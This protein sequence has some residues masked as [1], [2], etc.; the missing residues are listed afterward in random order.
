MKI[1]L[2]FETSK[3]HILPSVLK[4][5]PTEDFLF[6]E[7]TY[8]NWSELCSPLIVEPPRSQGFSLRDWGW[9]GKDTGIG[10][11]RGKTGVYKLCILIYELLWF[12]LSV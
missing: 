10:L 11:S 4:Y 1:H 6:I 12:I 5:I 9:A 3:S 8:I 2:V 7:F